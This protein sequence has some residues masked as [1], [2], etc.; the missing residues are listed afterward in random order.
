MYIYLYNLLLPKCGWNSFLFRVISELTPDK[1]ALSLKMFTSS[2]SFFFLLS[3]QHTRARCS[4][5]LR[6][7]PANQAMA[8]DVIATLFSS[9]T[10]NKICHSIFT[11]R[12]PLFRFSYSQ[13][14]AL[15]ETQTKLLL[16]LLALFMC[17]FISRDDKTKER[18]TDKTK[19]RKKRVRHDTVSKNGYPAQPC[20]NSQVLLGCQKE[21]K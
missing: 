11:V 13:T 15:T 16:Q 21:K 7:W 6:P 9:Y 1:N 10:H 3:T 18:T 4:E 5:A 14:R 2:F 17:S 12:P 8:T 20:F 19:E